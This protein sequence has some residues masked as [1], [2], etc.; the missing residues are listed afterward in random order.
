[1]HYQLQS[2]TQ[3]CTLFLTS[4][5]TCRYGEDVMSDKPMRFFASEIIRE[6]IFLR[7]SQEASNVHSTVRMCWCICSTGRI[8]LMYYSHPYF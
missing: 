5:S 6:Q 8:I 2:T 3:S 1:M 7:T 4:V